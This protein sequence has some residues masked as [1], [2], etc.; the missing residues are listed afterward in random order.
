NFGIVENKGVELVLGYRN[1]LNNFFYEI[2]TNFSFARNKVIEFDE[3]ER[4][5]PWQV[6]TGLPQGALLLYKSAGVFSDLAQIESMPHVSGA[7][8][9]DIIIEDI[10]KDGKITA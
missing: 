5:V 10:D 7:K 4:S 1:T 9:G 2:N 6:R 3:P 8:P